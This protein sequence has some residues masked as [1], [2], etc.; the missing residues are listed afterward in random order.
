MVKMVCDLS[1]FLADID[2]FVPV[3]KDKT[4]S[5][6]LSVCMTVFVVPCLTLLAVIYQTVDLINTPPIVVAN[7]VPAFP[8]PK[9]MTITVESDKNI[10]ALV[11]GSQA[12]DRQWRKSLDVTEVLTEVV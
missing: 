8:T 6:K 1:E 4:V 3:V 10:I 11:G 7:T 5:S 9:T 2:A 12:S